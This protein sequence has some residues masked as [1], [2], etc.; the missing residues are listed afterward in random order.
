MSNTVDNRVVSMEFDN[1]NF[2]KNVATS[3]STLDKLKQKLKFKGASDG[4]EKIGSSANKISFSGLSNGIQTVQAKFSALEVIGVTALANITKQAMDAGANL[5]KSFTLD[6]VIQGFQEYETQMGAIQTILANTESKGSTLSDVNAALDELNDYADKTIY[7]F[8]EMTRNIGTFTAA[9]VDLD[10]SVT[11]IKGIA[12]LAAISGSTSTQASTAMYQLSQALATGRVSLMD[13]NSVVNAGMGGEVFQTALKRTAT[14]MGKDVDGMIEKYG[15]F[16]ESLTEGG[17][18][19]AEVLTETLTQISGAY[20]EADLIAQG[21][22]EDQAKAIRELADTAVSAA[23][24]VKTFTGLMDTVKEAVGS[25]WAK[26]WQLLIGDFDESKELFTG[27]SNVISSFVNET[28]DARNN[29]LEGALSSNWDKLIKKVNEAGVE[30]DAFEDKIRST[31]EAYGVVDLD[32]IIEDHGSLKKAFQDGALSS[33]IL[34]TAVDNLNN[35]LTDL[36]SIE[37]ILKKGSTGED[38]SKVQ[39]ALKNLGYDLGEFGEKADGIDGIIGST[40]ENAIKAFQEASGLSVDGIIGP[41]TIAALEQASAT[42]EKTVEGV[43]DLISAITDMSGR[44]LILD[45]LKNAFDGLLSVIKPI[46]DAFREVFPPMTVDQLTNLINKV[47]ELSEG[48]GIS[49]STAD[50][51]QRTFKGL[52]TALKLVASISGGGLKL[53]FSGLS[54]IL[55]FFDKDILDVTASLG[56]A[57]VKFDDFVSQND[58]IAKAIE[59]IRGYG[60]ELATVFDGITLDNLPDKIL[61]GL[62]KIPEK[63]SEIKDDI[64][65]A[66][67]DLFDGLFSSNTSEVDVPIMGDLSNDFEKGSSTILK[68]AESFKDSFLDIFENIDLGTVFAGGVTIGLMAFAK[69]LINILDNITSPLQSFNDILE[70]FGKM[71]SKSFPKMLKAFAFNVRMEGVKQFAEAVAI[72]V[73]SIAVLTFLDSSKVNQAVVTVATLAIMLTALSLVVNQLSSASVE[74]NKNGANIAGLKPS[75]AGI[76]A[77]ILMLAASVKLIGSMNPDEAIQGF[78]GLTTLMVEMGV[79]A[80]AY[81]KLANGDVSKDIDKLGKMMQRMAKSM[82]LIIAVMKLVSMLSEDELTTGTSFMLAFGLFVTAMGYVSSKTGENVDKLGTTMIKMAVAMGLMAITVRLIGALDPW[83]LVRGALFAAAFLVF[84]KALTVVTKN[85]TDMPK[86]AGTLIGISVAIGTMAI[87]ARL[88]G[89]MDL[90]V[91]IKGVAAVTAFGLI[92]KSLVKSLSSLGSNSPKIASTLLAMSV[93]IGIL[94][95]IAALLSVIDVGGLAK[96]VTVVGILGLLMSIMVYSTKN[97][98]QATGSIIALSVAI[99]VMA[100]AVA[101][102]SLIE[103]GNLAGATAALVALMAMFALLANATSNVKTSYGTLAAMLVTVGVLSLVLAG[104]SKLPV[105]STL[106]NATALSEL[107]LALTAMTAILSQIGKA[108]NIDKAATAGAVALAKVTGIVGGVVLAIGAVTT[109][110]GAIDNIFKGNVSSALDS[111]I[112]ILEKVGYGLGSFVSS[113]GEG[114]TSKLPDIGANI[115]GF[116]ENLQGFL[117]IDFG[118]DSISGFVSFIESMGSVVTNGILDTIFEFFTGE[119]TFDSFGGKIKEFAESLKGVGAAFK[120]AGLDDASVQAAAK[121]GAM[122][123]SLADVIPKEGGFLQDLMGTANLGNFGTQ[124]ADFAEGLGKFSTGVK[125]AEI[126]ADAVTA[127]KN[128]GEMMAALADIVPKSGGMLQR[129]MGASDLGNFGKQM[130]D[131]GEGVSKFSKSVSGENAVNEDAVTAAKNAGEIMVALTK[132]I[133]E[134]GGFLQAFTGTS[135]LEDFGEKMVAFGKSMANYSTA[136]EGIS[137]DK[138]E[139]AS[140]ISSSIVELAEELVGVED[141]YQGAE[142]LTQ[143]TGKLKEFGGVFYA[144]YENIKDIEPSIIDSVMASLQGFYTLAQGTGGEGIDTSGLEAFVKSLGTLAT[145]ELTTFVQSMTSIS[146]DLI[147]AASSIS[148]LKDLMNEL[149]SVETSGISVFSTGVSDLQS[150]I[151]RYSSGAS[152]TDYASIG[153]SMNVVRQLAQLISSL[154]GLDTSGVDTLSSAVDKLGSMDVSKIASAFS[155]STSQMSSV[156]TDMMNSLTSGLASGSAEATSAATSAVD[157]MLNGI[158]GKIS[159]FSRA[160]SESMVAL[161]NGVKSQSSAAPAAI[162]S[163]MNQCV[164]TANGYYGSFYGSGSYVGSGL[165]AGISSQVGAVQSAAAALAAAAEAATRAKLQINS[166]SKVF[167]EIGK[168]IPE[169]MAQGVTRFASLVTRSVDTLST[170]AIDGSQ[171]A[172]SHMS[173]IMSSDMDYQPTIRPVVDLSAVRS[174]VG[175]MNSMLNSSRPSV[176]VLAN[177][178]SASRAMRDYRQNGGNPDVVSAINKLRKDIGNMPRNQYNLGG[179]TYDDGSNISEAVQT[180]VRAVLME[181]RA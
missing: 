46:K 82:L 177:L 66:I 63:L 160:G 124:M 59:K 144:Y 126:D 27:I 62:S 37:G 129:I 25:G 52:F 31:A 74:I 167:R 72:L 143:F 90:G 78:K 125:E 122:M 20:S 138:I 84:I 142:M 104:I 168:G 23:T 15:S 56:D 159:S 94:A 19:T 40:T 166:P 97:A 16:R 49:D 4:L 86:I 10:K 175:E 147:M 80:V 140:A 136:V 93:S 112:A 178:E 173:A 14:Q 111:G 153:S 70:G 85:A 132:E 53:A 118:T 58:L 42:T 157:G 181:G 108:K 135:D 154:A 38:V 21:Y 3:M 83:A 5:A 73:G 50:K 17:W 176:D 110:I 79:F 114:L 30:T 45:S 137:T 18:L 164:S 75:L 12:N 161:V 172:L 133:P 128:A 44:E 130:E 68:N 28:S 105:E 148:A 170:R 171:T 106:P 109:V 152:G 55:G 155:G 76:G 51:L 141:W 113:I 123:A 2:E 120:E 71:M 9:G 174:G 29:L 32:K 103:P 26:T 162:M 77:A 7:N 69:K 91:L 57:I 149:A 1:K 115:S 65:K 102:L 24:E 163:A 180:L 169:G 151:T 67:T 60:A 8:T 61:D 127:A 43:D 134:T 88:V 13:W 35:S 145:G 64:Q 33:D 101:G 11:A 96:G 121:A 34:K 98:T 165:A 41:D 6:P 117:A 107:M 150:A 100:A 89:G 131:F 22:T 39:E 36:S 116:A 95:G 48:L 156:G 47:H 87:I 54:A 179:I 81:G 119:S 92:V 146:G 99:G 158:N 139:L